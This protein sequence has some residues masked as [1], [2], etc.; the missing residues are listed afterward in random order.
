MQKKTT[1]FQEYSK[2]LKSLGFDLKTGHFVVILNEIKYIFFKIR[3]V[4]FKAVKLIYNVLKHNPIYIRFI[5]GK[6]KK[7]KMDEFSTTS[8]KHFF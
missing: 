7:K 6:T 1:F 5:Q 8:R 2:V 4:K 3:I